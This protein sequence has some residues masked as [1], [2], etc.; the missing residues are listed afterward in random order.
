MLLRI[1][2]FVALFWMAI[3]AALAGEVSS[4]RHLVMF[5]EYGRG[6]NRF[7]ELDAAWATANCYKYNQRDWLALRTIFQTGKVGGPLEATVFL[8]HACRNVDMIKFG[9]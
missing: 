6:G 5:F 2:P 7:V 9:D 3:N 8:L 4:H 1:L